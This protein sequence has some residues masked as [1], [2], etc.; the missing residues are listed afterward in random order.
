MGSY[1]VGGG[2][3]CAFPPEGDLMLVRYLLTA[4]LGAG[5]A[6]AQSS[7]EGAGGLGGGGGG[8]RGGGRGG[9]GGG[10]MGSSM[11]GGMPRAKSKL[12][13]FTDKLKLN[14][15]QQEQAQT[16]L[17]EAAQKAAPIREQIN[18]GRQAI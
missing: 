6:C 15:E 9:M 7:D 2:A 5:L 4:V 16:I 13:Q 14:K 1:S 10:D 11:G 3:P 17:T 12:E 18:R 8:G